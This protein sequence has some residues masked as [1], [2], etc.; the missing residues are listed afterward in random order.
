MVRRRP[1]DPFGATSPI[2]GEEKARPV[3][4]G[5]SYKCWSNAFSHAATGFA[6]F[7]APQVEAAPY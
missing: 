2:K 3:N 6:G 4:S 5:A 1:S 7:S